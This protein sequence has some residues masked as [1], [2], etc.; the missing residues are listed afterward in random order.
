M[1]SSNVRLLVKNDGTI[2]LKYGT[3]TITEKS[4]EARIAFNEW[5]LV[6][7]T[8]KI[9]SADLSSNESQ[10]SW[11]I[12]GRE[13][14]N[15]QLNSGG[16]A[17]IHRRTGLGYYDVIDMGKY[18]GYLDDLF[19]GRYA[20]T[21]EEVGNLYEETKPDIMVYSV[22]Q[23]VLSPSLAPSNLFVEAEGGGY[24]ADL[25]MGSGVAWTAKSNAE[26]LTLKTAA[27]GAGSAKISFDVVANP[28]TEKRIGTIDVAGLTLTVTQEALWSE[29]ENDTPFPPAEDGG[30]GFITVTTE[31]GALWQAVSDADWLTIIDEGDHAGTDMVMWSADPYT[32][33]TQCRM[34]TIT[35]ADHKIYITQRG[36]EL[37]VEPKG[38]TA[39]SIGATGQIAITTDRGDALWSVVV[40][41]PWIKIVGSNTG[42]GNGM[43]RYSLD[44]N[45]TGESRSGKI[46]VAG[47]EYDIV[48]TA[49]LEIETSVVGHG[50][51]S[52]G[53]EYEAGQEVELTAVADK[54]Y[55]FTSWGGD[56]F[57]VMPTIKVKMD[58]SK[59]VSATFIPESAAQQIVKD[60]GES[61]E[62]LYTKEQMHGLGLGD[63][64]IDVD[65]STGK[66]RIGVRLLSTP[67]LENPNWQPVENLD[68][69]DL[70]V[71]ANGTVGVKVPA[72]GNAK[73]FRVVS[74]NKES[75]E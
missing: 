22:S 33:T 70:D 28:R 48:Q 21:S 8:D 31:A 50:T 52:G 12:D 42:S 69:K 25:V 66:A 7:M 64:V 63:L 54:G 10:L 61:T 73:F 27:S 74:P 29:V 30:F 47:V 2:V 49:H 14:G 41:E 38:E 43:V 58:A 60:R 62:G 23:G 72:S 67:D 68:V 20:M 5:H 24:G 55:V 26:W 75:G 15:T 34:A 71:E 4:I 9:K 3:G 57:G 65:E 46:L 36:Y 16:L 18:N 19:I 51:I 1:I 53:G 11:Y 39:S 44:D 13:I 17:Y 59:K 56:V 45:L 35:V 40:T 32:D 6:T 37:S